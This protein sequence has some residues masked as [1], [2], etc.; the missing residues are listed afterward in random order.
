MRDPGPVLATTRSEMRRGEGCLWRHTDAPP[1]GPWRRPWPGLVVRTPIPFSTGQ[2]ERP[3]PEGCSPLAKQGSESPRRLPLVLVCF[4]FFGRCERRHRVASD[5]GCA[6]TV[7]RG[8]SYACSAPPQV[9]AGDQELGTLHSGTMYPVLRRNPR[10]TRERGYQSLQTPRT[11][12]CVRQRFPAR[13]IP[14]S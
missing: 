8:Q 10:D 3:A 11:R 13:V 2:L 12:S 1:W 5:A 4:F 6:G 7:A 9:A 14:S